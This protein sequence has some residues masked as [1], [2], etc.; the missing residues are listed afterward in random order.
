M[1]LQKSV[2]VAGVEKKVEYHEG[3]TPRRNVDLLSPH[4]IS[5]G[6][7]DSIMSRTSIMSVITCP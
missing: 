4:Q 2:A 1:D 5:F 6:S 7:R 3:L